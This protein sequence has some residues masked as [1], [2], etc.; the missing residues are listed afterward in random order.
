[1]CVSAPGSRHTSAQ[2]CGVIDRKGRFDAFGANL[3]DARI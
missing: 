1:V 3:H 2:A